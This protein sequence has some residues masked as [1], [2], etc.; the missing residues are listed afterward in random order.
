MDSAG[1]HTQQVSHRAPGGLRGWLPASGEAPPSLDEFLQEPSTTSALDL[2]FGRDRPATKPNR[3]R[4][5]GLLVHDIAKIDAL[6]SA[7]VSAIIH[8]ERF[9]S[10]EATWRG[11][12]YLTELIDKGDRVKIRVLSISW[13]EVERDFDRAADFDQ[14]ALFDLIYS[15]EFG[16]AGGEP[17]GLLVGDYFVGPVRSREHPIDDVATLKSMAATAAAAFAPFVCGC[18][19]RTLELDGF[20]ALGSEVEFE[21]LFKRDEYLRWHRLRDMDDTRFIGVLLPKILLRKPWGSSAGR[22]S[23]FC[24]HEETEASAP[25]A[26]LW[27]NAAFAFA[28]IVI[29]AFVQTGWFAEIR[30]VRRGETGAGLVPGLARSEFATDRPGIAF[31]HPVQVAVS[32]RQER[33]LSDLGFIPVSVAEYLPSLMFYSNQSLQRPRRYNDSAAN[34]N[35]RLSSMLQYVLCIGRFAHAIKVMGRERVASFITAA[36]CQSHMQTW[37][38]GYVMGNES[39]TI[40]LRTKYPLREGRVSAVEQPGRP[41]SFKLDIYL[42]PQLQLDDISTGI[43]LTTELTTPRVA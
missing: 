37:L 1:V 33:G 36:E 20:E 13:A 30:G 24:Y 18:D 6:L 17:Y 14:S 28:A 23:R 39:A 38:T 27:G 43:R 35:A 34:A 42:R 41:G 32:D 4:L 25:T 15:Q 16:M 22:H 19:P 21:S 31:K 10:L 9:A 40:E 29:R 2:W 12:K 3:H 11:V 7:Q 8:A 26:G 5:H